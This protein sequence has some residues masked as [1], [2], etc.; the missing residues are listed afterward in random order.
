MFI[1]RNLKL[2]NLLRI[3]FFVQDKIE[4]M[5]RKNFSS[6]V[7]YFLFASL[8]FTWILMT[9]R[10]IVHMD[11]LFIISTKVK[12]LF[13]HNL[14]VDDFFYQPLFPAFLSLG[15]TF[16]NAKLFHLNTVV[17]SITGAFF[18]ALTGFY[19]LKNIDC[20]LLKK[21]QRI[22][23]SL[24]IGF[25]VFGLHKWE[26]SFT[27]C[28]SFAVFFNLYLCFLNYFFY[29]KYID[30]DLYE[31][32]WYH[33]VLI[34][35][36]NLLLIFE[37]AAY[38]YGYILSI[39][40]ALFLI[41]LFKIIKVNKKRWFIIVVL[42]SSLLIFTF[43]LAGYLSSFKSLQRPASQISIS[44][45]FSAFLDRPWWFVK[46]YLIANSGAF[47]GEANGAIN[48]R[49]LF[50]IFVLTTYG[51]CIYSVIKKRDKRL[52]VPMA[53]IFYNIIS[54]VFITM[55]RYI[56]NDIAYGSSSRYTA[57]NLSGVLGIV[58]ILF[59][60]LLE[61][62]K[63]IVKLMLGGA[64]GIVIISY[65]DV[66]IKQL[67]ISPYRTCNFQ[68]MKAALLTG[69]NLQILQN[70]PIT[71]LNAIK[72][73]SKYKLN[74]YDKN[75]SFDNSKI[76]QLEAGLPAFDGLDK[77]G[78]YEKSNGISWTN[79]D[80][81]IVFNNMIT[82]SDSLVFD[83]NT[84]MPSIC[85][86]VHPKLSLKDDNGEI[87]QAASIK[88]T[89]D[90]FTFKFY[91]NKPTYINSINILSETIDASPD[92]RTLSFPFISMEISH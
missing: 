19:Y 76:I 57:F 17:E 47:W 39:T 5:R 91:F 90:L 59:F 67:Y 33:L 64:M 88:R 85:K 23:F 30:D 32:K 8:Y 80:A 81:T 34:I 11:I 27:S 87:Y 21:N 79:G 42:N 44:Q 29:F 13:E 41:K 61:E 54:C 82:S 6:N 73:L 35:F 53:L 15:F 58:T 37:T 75:I 50:G 20:F 16:I 49:V 89:G 69:K 18:L 51:Y 9:Y 83:L 28:F 3:K 25:I 60:Y 40:I 24:L 36:S 12:H 62:R 63:K 77:S 74:V 10:N 14:H 68:D 86:S 1:K 22:V 52:L 46:F 38:F 4:L 31:G 48:S 55:G 66:D 92:K 65:L 84:Y 70:D 7:Y 56:F 43:V 72:V 71:S 78:F 2:N 26:A 45:F